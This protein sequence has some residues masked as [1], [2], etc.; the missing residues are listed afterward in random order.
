M[1][2]GSEIEDLE[3]DESN[4]RSL[5]GIEPGYDSLVLRNRSKSEVDEGELGNALARIAGIEKIKSLVVEASS[6]VKNLIFLEALPRL[7]TLQLNGL[8]L[9]TLDGLEWFRRG[10]FIKI[11]TGKNRKRDIT[12]VA[13]TSITKLSLHSTKTE[14]LEVIGR[15]STIQELMLSNCPSLSL[16]R[17]RSVPMVTMSLFDGAIDELTDTAHV[18]SLR[19]LTFF[20]CRRLAKFAGDNGNITWMVVQRCNV[21]DFRTITTFQNLEHLAVV[22]IKPQLP[23]SAFAGL[24]RLQSLSLQQCKV[25]IDTMDL[26]STA[27]ALEKL[28]IAGLKKDVAAELS[29]ANNGVQVS[30]GVWSYRNGR[31][32]G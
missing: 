1:V 18:A 32:E 28:I 7:E 31:L 8:Q 16:E 12:K 3:L 24:E 15:S 26:K 2:D 6:M 22:S 27:T 25:Q 10:R 23:L 21:L 19:K 13:E 5:R 9:L 14:D 20:G 11:D 17:W 4:I 29:K 30:D